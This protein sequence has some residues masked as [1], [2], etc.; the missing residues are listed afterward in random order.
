M[1]CRSAVAISRATLGPSCAAYADDTER[2]PPRLPSRRQ[3]AM[4]VIKLSTEFRL[5]KGTTCARRLLLYLTRVLSLH[6]FSQPWRR[7]PAC[8]RARVDDGSRVSERVAEA[9]LESV[10]R[11]WCALCTGH[12]V[13]G[14]RCIHS[15]FVSLPAAGRESLSKVLRRCAPA[16]PGGSPRA[17]ER[18]LCKHAR[19]RAAART[20]QA[21][22]QPPCCGWSSRRVGTRSEENLSKHGRARALFDRASR[23]SGVRLPGPSQR[24]S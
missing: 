10:E 7:V 18:R 12:T 1:L 20:G 24:L 16:R 15:V 21:W 4:T 3:I 17:C 23:R 22:Q 2:P 8:A 14:Q 11:R 6:E 5:V 13:F 9:V 19:A